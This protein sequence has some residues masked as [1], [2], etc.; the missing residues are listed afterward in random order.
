MQPVA[1]GRA[2]GAGAPAPARSRRLPPHPGTFLDTRFLRPL[3]ITQDELAHRLGVSRRRVNEL[4][5]G[6]RGISADTALRLG[7]LFGTGPDIWLDL[8]QAWDV[9]QAGRRMLAAR[10]GNSMI[11][12]R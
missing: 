4:V 11:G 3:G 6:R 8:Q 2:R 1:T 7:M 5:K 10:D 12:I 9:Y